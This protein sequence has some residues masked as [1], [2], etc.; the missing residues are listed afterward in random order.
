[1]TAFGIISMRYSEVS[2]G[3]Y[4]CARYGS[5]FTTKEMARRA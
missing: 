4:R 1:M 5:M 2:S 3:E